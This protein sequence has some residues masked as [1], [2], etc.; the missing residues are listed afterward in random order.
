M[1]VP[2]ELGK[3]AAQVITTD[4]EDWGRWRDT[5]GPSS[6]HAAGWIVSWISQPDKLVLISFCGVCL[7]VLRQLAAG[8]L[9]R[10][11]CMC[12]GWRCWHGISCW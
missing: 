10:H 7:L 8:V 5:A 11:F 4:I 6:M 12:W 2:W 3:A 9:I 1:D